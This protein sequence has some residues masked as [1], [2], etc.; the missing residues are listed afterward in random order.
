MAEQR[1]RGAHRMTAMLA[2]ERSFFGGNRFD[3]GRTGDDRAVVVQY[4]KFLPKPLQRFR[5]LVR[6]LALLPVGNHFGQA[7][8]RFGA[9][10]FRVCPGLDDKEG[11]G[12]SER[13]AAVVFP[14]PHRRAFVFQ[15]AS[16][17]GGS[18]F[19]A[20]P[21]SAM[22]LCPEAMRGSAIRAASMLAA[23]PPMKVRDDPDTP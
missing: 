12:G 16:G 19:C 13:K 14:R 9:A 21:I 7:R 1:S 15:G 2:E 18:P 11:A 6:L 10:R 5:H 22:S 20:A 23:S 17:G 4:A 8:I 3:A